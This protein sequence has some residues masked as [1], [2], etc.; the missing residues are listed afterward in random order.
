VTASLLFFLHKV[1]QPRIVEHALN[2]Q[3]ELVEHT[4]QEAKTI[5]SVSIV[6]VE[7]DLFFGAIDLFLEQMGLLVRQGNLKAVI[8][9]LRHPEFF[10]FARSC[11]STQSPPTDT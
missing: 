2:S 11:P 3:G 7:G 5:P 8:L 6:H 9:R 10:L 4:V 1:S